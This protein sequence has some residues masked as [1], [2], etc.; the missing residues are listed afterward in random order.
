MCQIDKLQF[1]K[2]VEIIMYPYVCIAYTGASVYSK[3]HIQ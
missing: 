2:T 3:G 1:P